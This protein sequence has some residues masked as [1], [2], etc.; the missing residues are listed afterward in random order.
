MRSSVRPESG[1]RSLML[2]SLSESERSFVSGSTA[3]MSESP[4]SLSVSAVRFTSFERVSM[5]A[6]VSATPESESVSVSSETFCPPIVSSSSP[7]SPSLYSAS[8]ASACEPELFLSQFSS[9]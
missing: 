1:E 9:T 3:E 6:L 7:S 4:Q 2:L 8:R 5:S